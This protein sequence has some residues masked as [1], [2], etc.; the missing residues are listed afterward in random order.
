MKNGSV[1]LLGDSKK[2]IFSCEDLALE[3]G[4][5]LWWFIICYINLLL[6]S[7]SRDNNFDVYYLKKIWINFYEK[8]V[9]P[10]YKEHQLN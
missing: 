2:N 10:V 6:L 3:R 4:D 5:T 1:A 9:K 7:E 8:T